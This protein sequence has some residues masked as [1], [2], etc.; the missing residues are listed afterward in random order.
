MHTICIRHVRHDYK[1]NSSQSFYFIIAIDE[2]N[3]FTLLFWSYTNMS[4][5]FF[6]QRRRRRISSLELFFLY[7]QRKKK[8]LWFHILTLHLTQTKSTKDLRTHVHG[9]IKKTSIYIHTSYTIL[10]EILL[11]YNQIVLVVV[12]F[13]RIG[14]KRKLG[15]KKE[16]LK[17][18]NNTPLNQN[19]TNFLK[20]SSPLVY[21]SFWTNSR[22]QENTG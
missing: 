22:P 3:S 4:S 15:K 6:F 20:K 21:F 17:K 2:L 12:I 8:K 18:I 10:F 19:K 14:K 1:T 7:C 16:I 11:S 9:L 5:L 13:F